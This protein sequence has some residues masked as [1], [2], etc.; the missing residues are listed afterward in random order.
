[1]ADP[2]PL[3]PEDPTR[4][5]S[6][7]LDGRLGHGGFGTVYLGRLDGAERQVAVKVLHEQWAHDPDV[8]RRFAD[9]VEAARRVPTHCTVELIDADVEA[10]RPYMVSEFVPGP[11]LGQQVRAEGPFSPDGLQRLAVATATALE[12]IHSAGLAHRD[13][14]PE[15]VLLGPDGPRVIDFGI[16]R[17][18]EG[19][20]ATASAM[21]GT[22]TYMAPEQFDQQRVSTA[23]DIFAWGAV[24]VYAATGRPA[25]TGTAPVAMRQILEGRPEFHGY[26]GPL[27]PLIEAALATD[28]RARPTA[29]QL[30]QRLDPAHLQGTPPPQG[31]PVPRPVPPQAA[32]PAPPLGLPPS[33]PSGPSGPYPSPR[34]P[35]PQYAGAPGQSGP[36]WPPHPAP[37][38]PPSSGGSRRG[39]LIG[40]I[41]LVVVLLLGGAGTGWALFRD[42][43]WPT[44]TADEGPQGGDEARNESEPLVFALTGLPESPDP[45]R[46]SSLNHSRLFLQAFE[47]LLTHEPGGTEIEGGLAEEWEHSDDG[48]EW[49]FHLREGVTFHDGEPFDA[50]AVCANFDYRYNLTGEDQDIEYSYYWQEAF[51]GFA[52]NESDDLADSNY[53]SCTA[54]DDLTAVIEV[55]EYTT[56]FPGTFTLPA[57]GMLSPGSLEQSPQDGGA[58]LA[59]TGAYHLAD[60]DSAGQQ[61]T[62]ER[63]E[64]YWD[65]PANIA[66]L[67]FTG[68][69]DDSAREQALQAGEVHGSMSPTPDYADRL[70]GEGFNVQASDP[71]TLSYLGFH[72]ENGSPLAEPEVRRAIALAVDREVVVETLMPE[73]SSV[74]TQFVPETVDGWSS[75]AAEYGYDPDLA[76]QLLADAGQ[77]DLELEFCY[78]ADTSRVYMPSPQEFFEMVSDQLGQAGITVEG[79][80]QEWVDYVTRAVEGECDL[81]MLGWSFSYNEA[82]EALSAWF[83]EPNPQ[84]GFEDGA[85]FGAVERAAEEPDR[86]ARVELYQEANDAVMAHL[87]GLPIAEAPLFTVYSEEVEPPAPSPLGQERFAEA[88]YY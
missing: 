51:G 63:N 27:R 61:V 48:T 87:P 37:H 70:A 4:L 38:P 29:A 47:P 71:S 58:E 7:T 25:F 85:V 2:S 32:H 60:W 57:F 69:A 31:P 33:G 40:A 56:A 74:A 66:T 21:I 82:D 80:P 44:P 50:D 34:A 52:D 54:V 23:V 53:R 84:W 79:T 42:G 9:E 75:D 88:Y 35:R 19:V 46:S 76:G 24:M 73:G 41:G 10:A 64:G 86:D 68:I 67:T 5:G 78:P 16:A 26:A 45:F 49:T 81:Y 14:K 77:E 17:A 8:R 12:A 13:F 36:P 11:S 28:P 72:Q 55:G 65:A 18:L 39:L 22:P 43:S 59:G 1:M 15:N 83:A 62:M 3:R 30:L 6:Y 20:S